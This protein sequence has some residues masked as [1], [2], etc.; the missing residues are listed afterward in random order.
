[1]DRHHQGG[2][3]EARTRT[4]VLDLRDSEVILLKEGEIVGEGWENK[5]ELASWGM[6]KW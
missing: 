4:V 6:V 1:M 2:E 5:D 3:A